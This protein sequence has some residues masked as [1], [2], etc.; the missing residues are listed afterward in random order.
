VTVLFSAKRTLQLCVAV[1]ALLPVI[2]GAWG[3]IDGVRGADAWSNDH[4]RY[5]SG[6]LLAIGLGFWSTVPHIERHTARFRVLVG[7]VFVG[8][9]CRLLGVLTGDPLT[10]TVMAALT[11]ELLVTPLLGWWQANCGTD[12]VTLYSKSILP[13]AR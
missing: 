13:Q 5:L 3:V 10:H 7:L 12:R 4:Y 8:G 9:L 1:A 2:G 6:L 11:M